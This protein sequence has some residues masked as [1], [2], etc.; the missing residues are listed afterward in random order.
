[1]A[2]KSPQNQIAPGAAP[3]FTPVGAHQ[4]K[5]E[6]VLSRTVTLIGS[7]DNARLQLVSS[8]VSRA[9]ALLV[10]TTGGAYIRDLSSR[11]HTFVNGK[12]IR[13]TTLKNG[14]LIKIGRFT[15]R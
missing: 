2:G 7:R 15:F 4:G 10:N 1:M 3:S 9:H 13:E 5:P 8:T 14:D 11:E 12:E 6:M